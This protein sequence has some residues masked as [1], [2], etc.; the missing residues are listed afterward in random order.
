MKKLGALILALTFVFSLNIGIFGSEEAS[1]AKRGGGFNSGGL[2]SSTPSNS[3]VNP[4]KKPD[5]SSN[6]QMKS[7][8]TKSSSKSGFMKG[9]LF[10]GL[11]GLLLGGLFGDGILG[12][13][14]GLLINGL[15]IAVIVILAVKIYKIIKRKRMEKN[16]ANRF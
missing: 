1:A 6:S 8:P 12:A 10:G 3:T 2:K 13:I 9:L 15:A 7:T 11:A 5:S 16:W 4:V 14:L